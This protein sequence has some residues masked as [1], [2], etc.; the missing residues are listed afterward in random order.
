MTIV[1]FWALL[2]G[3]CEALSFDPGLWGQIVFLISLAYMLVVARRARRLR[4]L[5]ESS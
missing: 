1:A 4:L 2:A 5:S 3:V